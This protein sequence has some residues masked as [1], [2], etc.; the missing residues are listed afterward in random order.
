MYID[1]DMY[2]KNV[3]LMAILPASVRSQ[4]KSAL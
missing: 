2:V 1:I 4:W 3:I